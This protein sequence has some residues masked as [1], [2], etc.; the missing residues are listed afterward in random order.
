MTSKFSFQRCH[1]CNPLQNNEKTCGVC[2]QCSL[3]RCTSSFHVTCAYA[4]GVLFETSDWPF[5][6]YVT[7]LRHGNKDKVENHIQL[8]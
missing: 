8:Y 4:A 2:V 6:V 1:Y 7:C 5:P 3:G